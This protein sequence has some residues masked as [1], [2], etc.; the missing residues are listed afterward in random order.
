MLPSYPVRLDDSHSYPQQSSMHQLTCNSSTFI[1]T[2]L[3]SS[4]RQSFAAGVTQRVDATCRI[5]WAYRALS[6]VYRALLRVYRALLRVYRAL[7]FAA[8]VMQRVGADFVLAAVRIRGGL[9]C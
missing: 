8:A 2:P 4:H 3:L 7:L 1:C 6:R 9:I 5:M